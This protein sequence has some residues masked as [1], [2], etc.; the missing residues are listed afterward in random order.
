MKLS[1]G[2]EYGL[3]C[4]LQIG[5]RQKETG[6]GLSIPEISQMEGLSIPNV[7]KLM[8]L[9]RLGGFV[10]S[11]RGQSGGYRLAQSAD[12]I[13]VGDVLE[14]LGG[15]LFS[16]EFCEE[17]AGQEALCTHSVDCSI[18][19]L[20]SSVQSVIDQLLSRVTLDDLLGEEQAMDACLQ[21]VTDELIQVSG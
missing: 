19:S 13:V 6:G 7:A 12:L 14:A 17:H 2:E 20:W 21:N 4:L 1:A 15:R 11:V 5:R 10:A 3:R 9:L 8:R 16:P 18:R